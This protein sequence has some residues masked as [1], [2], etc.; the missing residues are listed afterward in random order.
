MI[1]RLYRHWYWNYDPA[2]NIKIGIEY[3]ETMSTWDECKSPN[4]E[5]IKTTVLEE[6]EVSE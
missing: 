6:V 3:V 2:T 5:F 1:V 4:W